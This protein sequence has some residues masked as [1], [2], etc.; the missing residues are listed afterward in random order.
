MY[1][2]VGTTS[3]CILNEYL[4]CFICAN[5]NLKCHPFRVFAQANCFKARSDSS[6]SPHTLSSHPTMAGQ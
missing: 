3:G 4:N 1:V 5:K 6:D 2:W